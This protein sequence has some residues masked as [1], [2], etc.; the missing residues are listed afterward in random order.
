MKIDIVLAY[1]QRARYQLHTCLG[2]TVSGVPKTKESDQWL[3]SLIS[4]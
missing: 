2:Y 3:L 4:L 1:T